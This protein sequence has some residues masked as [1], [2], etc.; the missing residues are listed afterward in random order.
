MYK[1]RYMYA[2]L[3][4]CVISAYHISMSLFFYVIPNPAASDMRQSSNGLTARTPWAWVQGLDPWQ[5]EGAL[6]QLP[7]P[8]T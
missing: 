1:L 4:F 2:L 3:L 7:S 6:S 8:Q 5:E